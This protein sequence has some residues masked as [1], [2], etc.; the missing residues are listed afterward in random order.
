MTGHWQLDDFDQSDLIDELER[1]QDWKAAKDEA[2]EAR[3]LESLRARARD[4]GRDAMTK[5]MMTDMAP[6]ARRAR[7]KE[8]RDM[9]GN[10][11]RIT[12]ELEKT[13][14]GIE[15]DRIE[16]AAVSK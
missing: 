6:A 15:A 5:S 14:A 13:R 10:L 2:A 11:T 9:T 1:F 3:H 16:A 12:A 7:M 8:Y 4:M